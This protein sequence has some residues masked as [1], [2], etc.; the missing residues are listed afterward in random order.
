MCSSRRVALAQAIKADARGV[1]VMLSDGGSI[2]VAFS[3]YDFLRHAT[4]AQRQRCR[5]EDE[6]MAIWWPALEEGINL[7]GLLGVSESELEALA[8]VGA[9]SSTTVRRS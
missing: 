9:R 6:G 7:A 4:P 3:D 1:R 5:V 8:G 2:K